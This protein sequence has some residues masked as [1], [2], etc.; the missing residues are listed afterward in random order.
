MVTPTNGTRRW[1]WVVL[2]ICVVVSGMWIGRTYDS[3]VRPYHSHD[4]MFI[5]YAADGKPNDFVRQESVVMTPN[6]KELKRWANDEQIE[7]CAQYTR[8][9]GKL[10]LCSVY[11][12]KNSRQSSHR[13]A[14]RR[15][16]SI[17]HN[18]PVQICSKIVIIPKR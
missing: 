17:T 14:F 8:I 15:Y 5:I 10:M 6:M 1:L 3:S 4:V 12:S 16:L 9:Y 13:F 2:L 11:F 18:K 7:L